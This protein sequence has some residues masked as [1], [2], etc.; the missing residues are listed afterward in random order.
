MINKIRQELQDLADEKYAKFNQKLCPDTQRKMLGVRVPQLRKLAQKI[1]KQDNWDE[2]LKQADNTCFE[3]VLLQGLVIAY[4]KL[5][6]DEKLEYVKWFVPKIDS[7]A[8]CDTFCPTL[9][10]KSQDLPKVWDFLEP[11]LHAKQEFEVRFTVI[12]MLDYY[13]T[14]EYVERVL[15]KL[16]RVEHEGYYVKMAVAWTIA[17][18]G[19]KFNEKAMNYLKGQN[20]LDKFTF[21]KALQKMCESYRIDKEQK[22][23]L[24]A[25]KRK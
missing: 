16:D 17:E 6:I 8:I 4:R 14:E 11:C 3:E 13:I 9:K 10:I 24:K 18:I 5:E 20:H 1:A 21:N 19:I 23:I 2:F 15:E 7:W 25:M 22:E 12:M